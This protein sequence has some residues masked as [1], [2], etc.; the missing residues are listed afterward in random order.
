MAT[1]RTTFD[2]IKSATEARDADALGAVYDE[3]VERMGY[4]KDLPA[5]S[6]NVTR[7]RDAVMEQLRD[8]FG[9][10]L[11]HQIGNEV[12]GDDRLAF[13]NECRYGSGERVFST[14]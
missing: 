3:N 5:S 13:T 7:G 11:T 6:P 1:A 2:A 12:V 10:D 8:V 9:R 4:R 14:T